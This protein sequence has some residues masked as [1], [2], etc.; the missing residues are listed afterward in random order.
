MDIS[1]GTLFD[2]GKAFAHL[3]KL[4]VDIGPRL[5]GT[6]GE[7]DAARYIASHF[8]S[9]GLKTTKQRYEIEA[10]SNERCRVE[11]LERG[12]WREIESQPVVLSGDTASRG[13]EGQIH[14]IEAPEEHLFTDE[15]KGKVALVYGGVSKKLQ[16]RL[17]E[18]GAKALL[19]IE[20][21]VGREPGRSAHR[22]EDAYYFRSV[23]SA[24]ILHDDGLRIRRQ[25][26]A[27]ARVSMKTSAR[28]SHS[29]NVIGELAGSAHPE[30]IIVVCGHYDSHRDIPGAAD[31]AGGT[32]IVM[33][34]AR[35]FAKRESMRTLRFIAFSGEETGLHGSKH[36]VDELAKADQAERKRKTFN[37][38]LDRTLKE[39]HV[40]T[41]N[42]DV[43]GYVLGRNA[44][45]YT[46]PD[47]IGASVRL[48]A[49]EHGFPIEVKHS[50]LSSDG[51]TLAALGIPNAQFS[52]WGGRQTGHTSHDHIRDLGAEALGACGAFSERWMTRYVTSGVV[53]P[54]ERKVEGE[55]KK[56][57]EKYFKGAPRMPGDL[58]KKKVLDKKL[59]AAAKRAKATR[60]RRR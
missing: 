56:H 25:G 46:G 43:H 31:N 57:V 20:Q 17:A 6:K 53:F 41:Y 32:A 37:E 51:T 22:L 2:A 14:F 47:D 35:V 30:D 13:V 24:R 3:R 9:L 38:K 5:G 12:K 49:K 59:K 34:L 4:S 10:H 7:H 23:P 33:E 26:I 11:L 58:E 42:I 48:L 8:R 29:F 36:Y 19:Q 54:F 28:K 52:R 44:M 27:R 40:F 15:V 45:T 60:K 18:L 16:T 1:D 50:A 39:R 21:R 55:S